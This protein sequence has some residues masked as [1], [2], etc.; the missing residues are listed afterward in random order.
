MCEKESE[1]RGGGVRG[2]RARAG[3]GAKERQREKVCVRVAE[4]D[5]EG[6][7][8]SPLSLHMSARHEPN[9]FNNSQLSFA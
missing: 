1:R 3:E 5:R 9:S 6:A 7:G 2:G 8:I 4:R